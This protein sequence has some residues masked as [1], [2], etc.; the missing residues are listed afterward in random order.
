MDNDIRYVGFQGWTF[1]FLG[2]RVEVNCYYDTSIDIG[3]DKN[4]FANDVSINL[5]EDTFRIHLG[6]YIK[7]IELFVKEERANPNIQKTNLRETNA[8]AHRL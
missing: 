5:M 8:L 7:L 3:K 6:G 2:S 1:S 4:C